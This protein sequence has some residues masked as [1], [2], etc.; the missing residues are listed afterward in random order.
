MRLRDKT[1]YTELMHLAGLAEAEREQG[2]NQF[3]STG[4][5]KSPILQQVLVAAV[6]EEKNARRNRSP[7]PPR[8]AAAAGRPQAQRVRANSYSNLHRA[9]G[10]QGPVPARAAGPAT[11]SM[12]E[13]AGIPPVLRYN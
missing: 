5:L 13:T 7:A 9:A 10:P 6:E 1:A 11:R 4:A 2:R 12:R 8:P 3:L